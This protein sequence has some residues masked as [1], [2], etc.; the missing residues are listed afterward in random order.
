MKYKAFLDF[1]IIEVKKMIKN[2]FEFCENILPEVSRSFALTIPML[3]D[4]L[5][6]PVLITY[7]MDRLLDNIEDEINGIELERKKNL[8]D[9]MVEIFNPFL[10]TSIS[11]IKEIKDSSKLIEDD[12]LHKLSNE[13]DTIQKAFKNLDINLQIISYKWLKEMNQGMKKYLSFEVKTFKDLDEYCYYVAGTVG[14]FLTDT[15]I[16]L[17]DIDIKKQKQLKNNYINAG[18]FLQK[19]NLVR[20]IRKD[21]KKRKKH[22]WPMEE[23]ELEPDLILKSYYKEKAMGGLHLMIED[24]KI[25]IAGLISYLEAIPFKF[26]G[27]RNFFCV[28]NA[29]GLVTLELMEDNEKLFYGKKDIKVK[30]IDFLKILSLPEKTFMKKSRSYLSEV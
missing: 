6:R 7:L 12:S 20:D 2:S 4:E 30:K 28:N 14:G 26:K 5:Y 23:L 9:M 16:Y 11:L 21:L 3:D 18:L 13:V 10:D 24:I 22:F 1:R 27:Y 8:M 17:S 15:M 19:I 29:L 25:H